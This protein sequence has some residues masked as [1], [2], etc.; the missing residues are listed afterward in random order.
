MRAMLYDGT[1]PLLREAEVPD[2]IPG[3]DDLLIDIH[4]C[5]VCRTDL[6]VV[7]G[8]LTDPK[9]PV[10]PGHEIVG[11]VAALGRNVTG[12]ALGERV[13]VPWLG[14]T[15]GHCRYCLQH[16]ENLCD[17]PGFTGYT[18]D[19]G[20]AERTVANSR[21]CFHLPD[22]Y[23]DVDAAPLLCAGLIGYR[24]LAMAGDA[25][26]IGIY[27][28][29]AAA[30]IVAQIAWHQQRAVYAF[31]SPGD[32]AAQ[33]FARRL[34]AAWA[35][36]SDERAPDE[37]DAALLF[38]PVGALVPV[39]LKAVAK[40]GIVVCG[41]IHMSDIPSFPYSLLWQERRV[42]SVANLTRDDGVAFMQIAGRYPL[43]IETTRYP[44]ADANRA[45]AD[46]RSG[47]LTG[48]AVLTMRERADGTT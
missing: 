28:F 21:Y 14:H 26:R 42:V 45:L 32:V 1:G 3:D 25:K 12:F 22:G 35:G 24:T 30:H 9:R 6:H 38:A 20:Y 34:G 7:D 16:R 43:E 15:C 31:T 23:S 36:G 46:L 18:I 5:G 11:T 17:A 8:D 19:G 2:P 29:G 47:R 27:G 40:G 10:I 37:L 4:A 48:A 13:G 39:A 44:L 33:Q 41:G